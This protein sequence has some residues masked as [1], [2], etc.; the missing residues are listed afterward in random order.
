MNKQTF[1]YRDTWVDVDLG[2]IAENVSLIKQQL[3]E[4][5]A[6]I[7]VVKA[8]AYGHGDLQVAQ[9]ALAAGASYLAVA[10]LDEAIALREQ[11]IHAPILVLGATRARDAHVAAA[12]RVTLTVYQTDW[13]EEAKYVLEDQEQLAVHLKLDTGMGRIGIRNSEELQQIEHSLK[14][15]GRFNLEGVFTHFST[16]DGPDEAYFQ[17]QYKKFQE[18]L[19]VMEH[20]PPLVHCSNSAAALRY[21]AVHCNAVRIGIA[22][23]GLAPSPTMKQQMSVSLKEAFSLHSKL[24]HVKKVAKGEK[25][26]YG[27]TYETQ[28]DEWIGTLPIGYADGWIRKLQGQEVLVKGQRVPIVGRICMD[29]CMIRLPFEV[30]VGTPVTLIGCN[31]GQRISIDEIAG[32]LDTI[33][34]EVPCLIGSRVPRVYTY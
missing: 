3:P 15:V 33:N 31:G 9:T 19:A 11:G 7:A 5:V 10:F 13:I 8:N 30:E 16:A 14:G 12:Y 23:Y 32:S 6:I 34:Y 4:E 29:Q 17:D 1:F 25:I 28:K 24:V 2:H 26:G 20:L 22:M 27:A 18:L 21:P